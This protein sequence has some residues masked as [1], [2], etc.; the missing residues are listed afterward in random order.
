MSSVI[1]APRIAARVWLGRALSGL[2]AAF[3]AVDAA[4]KLVLIQPVIDAMTQLG[5]PAGFARVVGAIEVACLLL[6]LW[7]RAAV[8]GAVLF[9]GVMG[10]AIASHVRVG[11]PLFSH[12]LFG[13][14]LGLMLWGG[15]WL[16]DERL[17]ALMPWR[18]EP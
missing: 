16:R 5:Y 9:T 14:Y 18:R 3:L 10:G 15:L 6:Y 11:D 4:I 12:I 17:R 8:L 1:S 7:P 13:V 2:A